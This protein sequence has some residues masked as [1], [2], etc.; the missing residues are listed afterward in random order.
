[1]SLDCHVCVLPSVSGCHRV[2]ADVSASLL[3]AATPDGCAVA[4]H[5]A[6]HPARSGHA[7]LVVRRR[8][9]STLI[10]VRHGPGPCRR[11]DDFQKMGRTGTDNSGRL[12]SA[13]S[14]GPLV[15]CSV[16]CPQAHFH[17]GR[18]RAVIQFPLR[19]ADYS[20]S[21]LDDPAVYQRPFGRNKYAYFGSGKIS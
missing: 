8:N 4:K 12:T 11:V 21:F 7:R 9:I 6:Y 13:T 1:F 18:Y 10:L 2:G 5:F 19:T 15:C 14:H 17:L 16:R 20:T 3:A